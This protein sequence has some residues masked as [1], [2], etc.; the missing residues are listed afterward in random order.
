MADVHDLSVGKN[1]ENDALHRA[2]E[3]VVQAEIGGQG[4]NRTVRQ[5]NLT[6]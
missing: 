6:D 3:M 4:N 2:D 5:F 1:L